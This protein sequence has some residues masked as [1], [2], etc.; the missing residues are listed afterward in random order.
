MEG[1]HRHHRKRIRQIVNLLLFCFILSFVW[2]YFA[3]PVIYIWN[4][5]LRNVGLGKFRVSFSLF[6]CLCS[7]F[8]FCAFLSRLW[9]LKQ[10]IV[11]YNSEKS[12]SLQRSNLIIIS[13]PFFVLLLLLLLLLLVAVVSW[14]CFAY[15]LSIFLS[16]F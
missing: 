5:F 4:F 1:K 2:L 11:R 16:F 3:D 12:K 10:Q 14:F 6:F 13:L 7:V 15:M 8:V 9:K